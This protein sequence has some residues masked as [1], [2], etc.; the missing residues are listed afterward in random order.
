MV[1]S[2]YLWPGLSK[3][4]LLERLAQLNPVGT[5]QEPSQ[6]T[7]AAAS[8]KTVLAKDNPHFNFISGKRHL[9]KQRPVVQ[10]HWTPTQACKVC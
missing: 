1:I 7:L 10:P 6:K 9:C 3:S 5:G 2:C 4:W 8:N